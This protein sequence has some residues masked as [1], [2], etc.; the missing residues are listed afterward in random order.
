MKRYKVSGGDV[1]NGSFEADLP[2]AAAAEHLRRHYQDAADESQRAADALPSG[3]LPP[4]A[5]VTVVRV[6]KGK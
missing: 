6:R 4:A 5:P 2:G 3:A 1:Y